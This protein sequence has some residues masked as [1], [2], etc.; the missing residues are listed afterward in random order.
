MIVRQP[1]FR[2]LVM[3]RVK[4]KIPFDKVFEVFLREFPM[5]SEM[6]FEMTEKA[7]M[8]LDDLGTFVSLV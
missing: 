6:L 1:L 8:E 5:K 2:Y 4:V 3:I 7:S